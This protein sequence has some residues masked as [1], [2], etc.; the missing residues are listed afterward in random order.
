ML[1]IAALPLHSQCGTEGE[2]TCGIEIW[3]V[4][5]G[6]GPD[7]KPDRNVLSAMSN[8]C[9]FYLVIRANW[10]DGDRLGYGEG[11]HLSLNLRIGYAADAACHT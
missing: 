10:A 7:S 6:V 5:F 2:I 3:V 8:Y 11:N 9:L 4:T 1:Q